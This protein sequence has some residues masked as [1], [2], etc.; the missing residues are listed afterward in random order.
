MK[1]RHFTLIKLLVVIAIIVI[2]AA[3]LLPALNKARDRAKATKCINNL[4]QNG[5]GFSLYADDNKG[6][7]VLTDRVKK[8]TSTVHPNIECEWSTAL[9]SGPYNWQD[10][11]NDSAYMK[12]YIENFSLAYCPSGGLHDGG[13]GEDNTRQRHYYTYSANWADKFTCNGNTLIK[14]FLLERVP[15]F[16]KEAGYKLPLLAES[17]TSAIS[18]KQN[19]YWAY[20]AL[21]H[22]QRAN[23]LHYDGHVSSAG[24]WEVIKDFNKDASRIVTY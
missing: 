21:R 16:E 6:Y 20:T 19:Y 12:R 11:W 18:R 23:F 15:V 22:S 17:D 7:V 10:D 5:F 8:M 3:M 14:I 2:L 13:A 4:K 1:K 24:R 9:Y